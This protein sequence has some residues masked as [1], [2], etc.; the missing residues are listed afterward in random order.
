MSIEAQVNERL[1]AL[2]GA[3]TSVWLV[4]FRRNLIT[5]GE[6]ARLMRED[7]LRGV[8]SNPAIF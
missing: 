5:S 4:Q 8:T 6:L 7:S 1:A 3:G 2:T